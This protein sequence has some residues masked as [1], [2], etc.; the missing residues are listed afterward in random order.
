MSS[1]NFTPVD[2]NIT[3]R[4][5]F[6]RNLTQVSI[7]AN[8]SSKWRFYAEKS[9]ALLDK[10]ANHTAMTPNLQQTYMTPAASKNKVYFMYV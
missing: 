6:T 10:L 8:A 4:E 2:P 5:N 1:L 7:P 3:T 9:Q